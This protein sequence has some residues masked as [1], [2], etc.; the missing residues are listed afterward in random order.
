MV[1][2]TSVFP[3]NPNQ[4]LGFIEST[5]T[6][7]LFVLSFI[8]GILIGATGV[9]GVLLIPVLSYCSHLNIHESMGTALFS[10]LF[11]GAIATIVYQRH[12]SIDWRITIPVCLGSSLTSYLGAFFNAFANANLLYAILSSIIILSSLY[13]MRPTPAV[14]LASAL[15]SKKQTSLLLLV[16]CGVG[17]L[18]GLTGIG[19]GLVSIPIMLTLGFPTFATIG[20]GQVLQGIVA[21]FGSVS[22]VHNNFVDFSLV[23]WITLVEVVGVFVGVKIAHKLP[24]ALLK[25]SVSLFCL[26]L[27][28]YMFAQIFF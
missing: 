27:G 1:R 17:F 26:V 23:W 25:K 16:G 24:L 3:S 8:I 12:G 22:N 6:P 2:K 14:S 20:T 7:L 9:G 11:T 19:G 5:M 21:I 13:T 28:V 18:S 10:F 4:P 15:S